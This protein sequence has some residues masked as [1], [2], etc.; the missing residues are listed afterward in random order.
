MD[1]S[2]FYF[3]N[4][5]RTSTS[6]RYE[7][8]LEGAR[9]ADQNDFKAIWTPERHFHHF[10]GLYPNP[11]L[12]SAAIAA[13]TERIQIRAGST[14]APLHH[15]VR[16][17]EEWSVVDNLSSGR[18]GVA[19]ASGWHARD[20][21][22]KPGDYGDRKEI[23]YERVDQV[24]RL[25]RGETLLF[26]DGTAEEREI[27]IFPPPIQKELPIW[28]TSAGG[29]ETWRNAGRLGVGVLTWALGN[30]PASLTSK[31]TAYRNELTNNSHACGWLGHV[32]LM[33]HAY[34]GSGEA[35]VKESVR[36]PMCEY[37]RSSISL[38]L[39]SRPGLTPAD[40][41]P[42][43]TEVLVSRAFDNYFEYSSMLGTVSKVRGVAASFS[44]LGVDEI[45][46]LIDFGLPTPLVLNGLRQLNVV[47]ESLQSE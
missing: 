26:P 46:C 22:L 40:L 6:K 5:S 30:D 21:I 38:M 13:T 33:M 36:G 10:G 1:L 27:T 25:W 18:A 11:S 17:A 28:I 47:R 23:L 19:F 39:A 15:P 43:D 29:V 35:E 7:L 32:V 34:V 31:I 4:D 44:E 24:R 16:I 42:Q 20:F 8:L 41:S 12:T 45:A 9:F 3:A 2:L 37:L 14:V